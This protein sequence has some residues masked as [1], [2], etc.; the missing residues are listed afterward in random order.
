MS[1]A[2]VTARRDWYLAQLGVVRYVPRDALSD[3]EAEAADPVSPQGESAVAAIAPLGAVDG[4]PPRVDPGQSAARSTAIPS[5]DR[6]PDPQPFQ[7]RI[8]FWQP[9]STVAVLSA[10]PPGQRP[11][12][13]QVTMLSN[14]LKAIGAL[15]ERLPAVDLMDWPPSAGAGLAAGDGLVAARE[16]LEIFLQAKRRQQDFDTVLLMGEDAARVC[17]GDSGI[18]VGQH[19]ALAC[20]AKGIVTHSL[21]DM[22]K[23]PALKGETWQAIRFLA[24]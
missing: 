16:F 24:G 10:M 9:A 15:G 19:L 13:G 8:G 12:A 2:R 3:S 20:G 18:A 7:C 14:L 6:E 21:H 4:Q 22:E 1:D 5:G 17:G 23:H 11:T